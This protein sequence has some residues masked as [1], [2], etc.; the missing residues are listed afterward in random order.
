MMMGRSGDVSSVFLVS[1]L[2]SCLVLV[3][4][5]LVLVGGRR[6][7]W[8]ESKGRMDQDSIGLD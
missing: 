4:V 5:S 1:L 8:D 2:Y 6:S 3:L 7:R